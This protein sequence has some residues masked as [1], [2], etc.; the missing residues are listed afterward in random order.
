[1]DKNTSKA[2]TNLPPSEQQ[3][4]LHL[5]LLLS[6]IKR[7][8]IE[9]SEILAQNISKTLTKEGN[10]CA[11]LRFTQRKNSPSGIRTT[12]LRAEKRSVLGRA[13]RMGR[14]EASIPAML[15]A[16]QSDWQSEVRVNVP[17]GSENICR[18]GVRKARPLGERPGF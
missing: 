11:A 18:K 8:N 9:F 17:A 3:Q 12:G 13:R 4:V 15:A 6:C 14:L 16:W 5:L 1:M 2:M 10:M 7:A